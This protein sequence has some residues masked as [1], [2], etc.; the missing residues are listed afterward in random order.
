MSDVTAAVEVVYILRELIR[1]RELLNASFNRGRDSM[2]TLLLDADHDRN[3]V[4]FDGSSDPAVNRAIVAA[5]H[6]AFSGNLRGA[7]IEFFSIGAKEVTFRGAP[8]LTVKFPQSVKQFQNRESFRV[9][10]VAA[11]CM[12]PVPGHGY[13][14]VPVQEMSVG[15]TLLMVDHAADAFHL[16]QIVDCQFK[17]GSQ[18]T[19]RCKV[20]V[21][22]FKRIGRVMGMGCRFVSLARADE[23]AIARFVS[24]QERDSITKG[25]FRL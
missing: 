10:A 7:K 15:G 2:A 5:S 21:R 23:S 24:Q 20:E 9:K 12:L 25:G 11:T 19:L 1:T 17:L 4:V 13:L 14:A 8:A 6:V 16:G 22:G 3:V 18:G